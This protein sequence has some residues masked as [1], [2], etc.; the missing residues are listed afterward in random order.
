MKGEPPLD[1]ARYGAR[2]AYAGPLDTR[3]ATLRALQSAHIAAIP[4][5]AIDVWLGA[6]VSLAPAAIEDKLLRRGRGG[7]CY[8]QNGLFQ[9]ALVQLGFTVE[10]RIARV[11]WGGEGDGAFQPRTHMALRVEAEGQPWLVDVGFGAAVP[12]EPLPWHSDAVQDT[13]LG[14][15]RL[16]PTSFGRKLEIESNGQWRPLYEVFDE[17]PQP[18]DFEVSNWFTSTHPDS[19]FRRHLIVARASPAG[20]TTLFDAE[21]SFRSPDGAVRRQSLNA[22]QLESVLQDQF[23]LVVEPAWRARLAA[24]TDQG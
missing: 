22:A 9:R 8:E 6:G 23:Q 24:L 10:P 15:Y 18:Q 21:L 19:V 3:L 16:V 5:E 4:F 7:Y 12:T 2:I 13:A 1:L 17:P 20:R 11:L 14:R